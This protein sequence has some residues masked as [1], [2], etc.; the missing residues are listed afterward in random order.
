LALTVFAF[1]TNFYPYFYPHYVA[2]VCC[3]IL[4]V[5]MRGLA[6][7]GPGASAVI[8]ATCIAQFAF[9]L[10]MPRGWDWL[11]G[12]DPQGRATI[13]K[14]LAQQFGRQLVF[15]HFSPVHGFAEW[16]HNDADPAGSRVIWVHD[17]GASEDEQLIQ[18]F[19]HRTPWL[20]FPDETPPRLQPFPRQTS[21]FEQ[22]Q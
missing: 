10:A 8:V 5:A 18:S 22:V 12:P 1:G 4:L 19:P 14:L 9:G 17:R 15:V 2:A 21:P 6:Q 13:D 3:V 7:L 16:V 11:N 20:L